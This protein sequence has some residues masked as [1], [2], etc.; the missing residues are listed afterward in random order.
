MSVTVVTQVG[1]E[2]WL[3]PAKQEVA[4]GSSQ[5]NR[6]TQPDVVRHEDEHEEI[7]DDEL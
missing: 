1:D 3:L 5:D 6:E 7:A 4:S 2:D